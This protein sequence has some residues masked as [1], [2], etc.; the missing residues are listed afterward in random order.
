MKIV[1]TKH[2][3]ERLNKKGIVQDEVKQ[4][5]AEP[6]SVKKEGSI[7]IYQFVFESN[8]KNYLLMIL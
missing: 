7:L 6:H 5:L 4:A 8:D 2:A 1:F 3:L